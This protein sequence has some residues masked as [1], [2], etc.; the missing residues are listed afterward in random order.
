MKSYSFVAIAFVWILGAFASVAPGEAAETTP[1]KELHVS[2]SGNDSQP[3]TEDK[4]FATL[5][6]ARDEI[7][8]IKAEQGLPAGGIE[9]TLH[10]GLYELTK[11]VELT[12]EDSGTD[13]APITYRARKGEQVRISGGKRVT[14]WNPV[15]DKTVLD[16]L[17]PAAH[18]QVVWADLRA[19]GVSDFGEMGGGFGMRGGPGLE[20][21]YN[22]D[23][24]TISRY[25]NDGF[26]KITG[27][28]GPTEK[29]IGN[30]KGRVEGIFTYEGGR[31]SRWKDETEGWVLGYWFHD[32]AEQRQRIESIDVEAK[33]MTLAKP[34]HHYGYR[35]GQWFYGFN[36]LSEIDQ[37]GEWYLDRKSGD[38]FFWPPTPIENGQATISVLDSLVTLNAAK[39]VTLQ[40]LTLEAARG[41]AITITNADNDRLVGCTLRNIGSWAVSVSGV[42]SG[43]VGCDISATGDG[44]ISL[45]GGN[46]TT[47]SP[48]GLYADNNHIH[49]WSRWNR[50]NR[51]GISLSGVGNRAAHNLL[52]HSPHSAIHF[53]G[54]DHII[55]F[56]EIHSVCIESNDAGAIYA[57]RNWTMRG[58][59]IRHNHLHHIR[60]F[61]DRG[62][63][64]IYLDDMYSG[65]AIYGNL[66]HDV[67]RA[68]Y[69]GGGHDNSI[70]NN[71]FV[72]CQPAVH[73]DSR[74]L[75]WAHYWADE[76][77]KEAQ[78]KGTLSGIRFDQPPFSTRYPLL[79]GILDNDPAAPTGSLIARNVVYGGKWDE[80][81]NKAQP[82]VTFQD[83][84]LV[85]DPLLIDAAKGNFQ[86]RDDSPA[87]KLGF[88]RIPIE[89]I[90]LVEDDTRA[91]W[92]VMH[93]IRPKT[94]AR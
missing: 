41:T 20:L 26:I 87:Y 66:F 81:D 46:R 19:L 28:E 85:A 38:L 37:P 22:D 92:P 80:I 24:M 64:G 88:H 56:N 9:V 31:P 93:M 10:G 27:V 47:L 44:G 5:E 86:L 13:T 23:P 94:E 25:P 49:D 8:T 42:N 73:V 75:G 72:D 30:R 51:Q 36:L 12:A 65:T 3:G 43:V 33:R 35:A 78:D 53:S 34:Y 29:V 11:K 52:H 39:Y 7:R 61:Q 79:P 59:V 2:P 21:F 60:G 83:N 89:Q 54:N 76:W 1:G 17:D 70:E 16:R 74:A 82:Y 67:T 50:M 63:I 57:G 90:G 77:I 18:G 58:T 91:S 40:G 71:I 62:C 6:R 69:I 45:S 48:A 15:T 55:E 4:P 14:D 84:L 68:A 32:W